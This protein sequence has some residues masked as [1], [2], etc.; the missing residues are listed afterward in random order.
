MLELTWDVRV[1]DTNDSEVQGEHKD[2]DGVEEQEDSQVVDDVGQHGNDWTQSRKDSQEEECLDQGQKDDDNHKDLADELCRSDRVLQNESDNGGPDVNHIGVV[3]WI[4]EINGTSFE[5][6]RPVIK[7]WVE[8][9]DTQKNGKEPDFLY[10]LLSVVN[11]HNV[12]VDDEHDNVEQVHHATEYVVLSR[13]FVPFELDQLLNGLSIKDLKLFR[14]INETH[15]IV[16]AI[17][18]FFKWIAVIVF[19]FFDVFTDLWEDVDG[20]GYLVDLVLVDDRLVFFIIV[21]EDGRNIWE[22]RLVIISELEDGVVVSAHIGFLVSMRTWP[23]IEIKRKTKY[24]T[25]KKRRNRDTLLQDCWKNFIEEEAGD[26]VILEL[27]D[28][29]NNE[30]DSFNL[31]TFQ[32]TVDGSPIVVLNRL[33]FTT[34]LLLW[35]LVLEEDWELIREEF[36]VLFVEKCGHGSAI[37]GQD[38]SHVG[39]VEFQE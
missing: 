21:V 16:L 9:T 25:L 33:L 1:S 15:Q 39:A 2:Q 31:V 34:L 10:D 7:S 36:T 19:A 32:G 18:V 22:D 35:N 28:V 13:I 14:L 5:H 11:I 3:P 6:L 20:V 12:D 4:L 37:E 38:G 27:D 29:I 30:V 8:D 26:V 23:I 24:I 17:D